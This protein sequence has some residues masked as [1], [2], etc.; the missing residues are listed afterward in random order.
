MIKLMVMALADGCKM[1]LDYPIKES[2]AFWVHPLVA[3]IALKEA[4]EL[5]VRNSE[6]LGRL[7]TESALPRF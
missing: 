4:M 1:I 3:R 5:I 2:A 7:G 6:A